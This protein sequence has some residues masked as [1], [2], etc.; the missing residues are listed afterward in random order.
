[1]L[2]KSINAIIFA[3]LALVFIYCG[4]AGGSTEPITV[5]KTSEGEVS[6]SKTIAP[7]LKDHCIRCHGDDPKGELSILSYEAVM[8]GGKSGNF[9]VPGDPD[10]SRLITSVEKTKEPFMPPRIFP[11]LTPDRIQA[12]RRWIAEGAKNN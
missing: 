4:A 11:A 12:I 1:M 8:K 6:F 3:A 10:N 5:E 2:K 9:V 7:I